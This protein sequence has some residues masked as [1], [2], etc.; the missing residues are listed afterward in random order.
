MYKLDI[1]LGGL[2][3]A[4]RTLT[5]LARLGRFR[6]I[7]CTSTRWRLRASTG[8][9]FG[10]AALVP[11]LACLFAVA[12]TGKAAA[13]ASGVVANEDGVTVTFQLALSEEAYNAWDGSLD[14]PRF[15]FPGET[16]AVRPRVE[17]L[18]TFLSEVL[19]GARDGKRASGFTAH[20][21]V[22]NARCT[23]RAH[24]PHAG[25][26]PDLS[27][28]TK[29]KASGECQLIPT[30]EGPLPP[31]DE[32]YWV[33]YLRLKQHTN[34]VGMAAYFKSGHRVRWTQNPSQGY[35]GTQVFR[36]DYSC[37]N[38]L[39]EHVAEIHVLAPGPFVYVGPDP[40]E[41]DQAFA[42]VSDCPQ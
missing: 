5:E 1:H 17:S 22:G 32:M 2:N 28:A 20:A 16:I 13:Q 7:S 14:D 37:V 25:A 4:A 34:Y 42:T 8:E 36:H 38:G 24:H 18:D 27:L 41:A 15:L 3:I 11:L 26:G 31:A 35:P 29:A 23:I 19:N 9:N 12:A 33:A 6:A 39:Y 30:G 40:I 10:R 21:V